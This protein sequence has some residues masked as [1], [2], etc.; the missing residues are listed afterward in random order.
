MDLVF[1]EVGN[2]VIALGIVYA[3]YNQS[4][5]DVPEE[6]SCIC[7]SEMFVALFALFYMKLQIGSGYSPIGAFLAFTLFRLLKKKSYRS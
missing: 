6:I 1:N 5:L 4:A 7:E 2:I 3:T